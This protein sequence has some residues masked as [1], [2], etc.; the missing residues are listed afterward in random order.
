MIVLE[1][2]NGGDV[3]SRIEEMLAKGEHFSEKVASVYFQQMLLGVK[4]CHSKLVV[5]R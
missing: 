2:A 4:H 1:L 3:M 5:H